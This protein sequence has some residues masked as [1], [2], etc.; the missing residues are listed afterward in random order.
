[1]VEVTRGADGK[2]YP[3]DLPWPRERLNQARWLAHNLVHRDGL[4]IKAAQRV[5]LESYALRR[6][7]GAIHKDLRLF[8]CPSCRDE[9][10]DPA[11]VAAE[12]PAASVHQQP[13]GLTSGWP[14]DG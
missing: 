14:F 11:P 5:M 9:S 3:A 13:G 2:K 10:P 6:S 1:M 12:Q 7:V 4:T 8:E